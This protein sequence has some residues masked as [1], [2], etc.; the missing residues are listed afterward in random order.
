MYTMSK[1][2][3][4]NKKVVVIGY[5]G[6]LGSFLIEKLEQEPGIDI[7]L[8]DFKRHSLFDK[9]SLVKLVDKADIIYYLA[10]ICDSNNPKIFDVNVIGTKN[11]LDAISERA[12]N[13]HLIFTSTF[14][15]YKSPEKKKMISEK[16]PTV[17]NTQYG[18]TK[19]VAEEMLNY[20]SKKVNLKTTILRISNIYGSGMR[21]YSHSVVATFFEDIRKK[22]R[23]VINGNGEQTRDFIYVTDVVDALLR[24]TKIKNK[25]EILNICSGRAVSLN[26]LINEMKKITKKKVLISYKRKNIDRT[27]WRGDYTKVK[28]ILSWEPKIKL[29]D[30]LTKEYESIV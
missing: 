30:G 12:L 16:W 7:E 24:V 25:F 13:A 14:S 26:N 15:V 22:G 2:V 20:Y 21:P 23:V 1:F 8:F 6:F 18:L 29:V 27:H 10:G 4:M 28:K 17:P 19:L 11:L 3:F 9:K 5:T